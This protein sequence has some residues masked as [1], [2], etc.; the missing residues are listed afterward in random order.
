MQYF[1]PNKSG[2][3]SSDIVPHPN[4]SYNGTAVISNM[5]DYGEN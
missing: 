1:Y 2:Y 3:F 4:K 5:L